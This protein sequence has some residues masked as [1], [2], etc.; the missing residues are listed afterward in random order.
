M[1][2]DSP[3]TPARER[4]AEPRRTK[5]RNYRAEIKLAGQPIYQFRVRDVSTKG[6]GILIKDDSN[7]LSM[8][9]VGQIINVN[10]ISPQGTAPCGMHKAQVK[11]LSK[12]DKAEIK[13]HRLVGILILEKIDQPDW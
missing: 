7:F 12:P 5:L 13:G 3:D 4:R 10:F 6:A 1:H 8:I 2:K 9:E 11:H